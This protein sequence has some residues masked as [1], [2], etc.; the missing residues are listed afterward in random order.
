MKRET[1][2]RAMIGFAAGMVAIAI[3]IVV[4]LAPLASTWPDGLDSTAEKLGFAGRA[5]EGIIKTPLADYSVPG[6]PA[7][8][9]TIVAGLVGTVLALAVGLG[10]AYIL[11]ATRKHGTRVSR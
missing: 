2:T 9:S 5:V 7:P 6:L 10:L 11:K 3:G 4:F 8:W 1:R